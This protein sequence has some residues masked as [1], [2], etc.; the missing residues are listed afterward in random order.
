[1]EMVEINFSKA[2]YLHPWEQLA[3]H[4]VNKASAS[5]L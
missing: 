2:Q 3:G 5:L 4:S 1:M